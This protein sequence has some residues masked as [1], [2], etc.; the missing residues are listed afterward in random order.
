MYCLNVAQLSWFCVLVSEDLVSSLSSTREETSVRERE[1]GEERGRREAEMEALSQQVEQLE[2]K[3][4]ST[5]REKT[6]ASI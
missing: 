1:W 2:S 4:S 3:L 5:Q 6:E